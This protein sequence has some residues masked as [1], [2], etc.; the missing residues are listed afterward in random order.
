MTPEERLGAD[1]LRATV[2]R[3]RELH[4]PAYNLSGL[5]PLC[6]TCQ[7]KTGVHE[8]GCWN[9]GAD[10][11]PVCGGCGDVYHDECPTLAALGEG[12]DS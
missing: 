9:D 11:Q 10:Y 5:P 2:E 3:V 8:C 7:G 12:A 4:Y 1:L 6:G